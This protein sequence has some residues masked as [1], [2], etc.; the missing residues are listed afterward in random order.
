MN[1]RGG[2]EK[3]EAISTLVHRKGWWEIFYFRMLGTPII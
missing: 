2:L 1:L 3:N